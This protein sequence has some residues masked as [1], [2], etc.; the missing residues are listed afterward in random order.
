MLLLAPLTTLLLVLVL[1]LLGGLA[2]IV[3]DD[4][5]VVAPAARWAVAAAGPETALR[6]STA[7]WTLCIQACESAQTL[8]SSCLNFKRKRHLLHMQAVKLISA[9]HG[10]FYVGV[11][12]TYTIGLQPL[13]L[14]PCPA[15]E[16][17]APLQKNTV[18]NSPPRTYTCQSVA[19]VP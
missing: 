2:V 4:S 8:L 6:A 12:A 9:M 17:Q 3:V 10:P 1:V 15:A 19:P 13:H 7:P 14:A 18:I 11:T 5:A 16:P